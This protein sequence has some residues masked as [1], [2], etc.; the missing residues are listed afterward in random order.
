MVQKLNQGMVIVFVGGMG[1]SK[2][3]S[4]VREAEIYSRQGYTVYSNFKLNF[5]FV[6]ID[7]D[8]LRKIIRGELELD[9]AVLL[10]DEVHQI[11]DSRLSASKKNVWFSYMVNQS[12]KKSV[13]ILATTQFFSQVD[14]R[15]RLATSLLVF[16]SRKFIGENC[17][18]TQQLAVQKS[19]EDFQ[20]VKIKSFWGNKFFNMYDSSEAIHLGDLDVKDTDEEKEKKK[21]KVLESRRLRDEEKEEEKKKRIVI[22]TF[23]SLQKEINKTFLKKK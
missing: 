21:D 16:C 5:P 15:L 13:R 20:V 4:M 11:A 19:P 12:R 9:N 22:K 17:R 8:L 18:V 2:T 7:S 10:L 6:W 1:S 23:D 14:R 3:L